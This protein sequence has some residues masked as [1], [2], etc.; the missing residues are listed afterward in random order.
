MKFTIAT[1]LAYVAI[2]SAAAIPEPAVAAA[3]VTVKGSQDSYHA[4]GRAAADVNVQ[5]SHFTGTF[6]DNGKLVAHEEPADQKRDNEESDGFQNEKRVVPVIA[7]IGSAAVQGLYAV[8]AWAMQQGLQN[9][10]HATKWN[11]VRE[12]FT[13]ATTMEMWN[14]NPN[15]AAWPAVVCYNKGYHLSHMRDVPLGEI[16]VGKSGLTKATLSLG[17]FHTDSPTDTT[18]TAVHTTELQVI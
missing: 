4:Q 10:Y 2:A 17:W 3:G 13:Q 7:I 18:E 16:A 12:A 14:K 8:T 6:D 1:V 9:A 15:S 5:S 11:A